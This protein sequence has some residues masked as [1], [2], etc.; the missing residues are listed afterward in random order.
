MELG[1][2]DIY[3]NRTRLTLAKVS[4]AVPFAARSP[5]AKE[6]NMSAQDL[7]EDQ[8][9]VYLHITATQVR[10]LADRGELPGRRIAGQWRFSEAEVHVWLESRIGA[11]SAEELPRIQGVVDRWSDRTSDE[12]E[13]G[14]LLHPEAIEIPLEART[15]G[16]V[17]RRMCLL[18]ERTG[19]LWDASRMAEAVQAREQLHTT[20]LDIGVALLHPR[21]PQSSILA[22]PLLALGVSW[23]PLPFGNDSGHL[24]DIFFLICST[25]DRVHLQVLAKLSRLLSATNFLPEL[26]KCPNGL[27]A[28][29]LLE[30]FAATLDAQ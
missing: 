26:R 22:E 23:Q 18:A 10:K 3:K 20:A 27:Q 25:D 14:R 29:E 11:S 1:Y 24:T 13:L 28:H 15:A 21:R 8:L 19:L 7:D 12:G 5:M 17:V 6:F 30:H 9:A 2:I 16:S 4:C